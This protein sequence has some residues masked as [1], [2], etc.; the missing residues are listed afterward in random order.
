MPKLCIPEKTRGGT[1]PDAKVPP[2]NHEM[3]KTFSI[4]QEILNSI[5]ALQ[6]K[7]RNI[8]LE[9]TKRINAQL[10]KIVYGMRFSEMN[11]TEYGVG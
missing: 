5:S 10:D 11:H 3:N 4:L 6:Q 9:T 2:Q 7:Q 1:M 8:V